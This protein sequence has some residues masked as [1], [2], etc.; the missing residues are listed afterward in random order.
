MR[1]GLPL[2][3]GLFACGLHHRHADGAGVFAR[4]GGR[5]TGVPDRWRRSSGAF[6]KRGQRQQARADAVG[7]AQREQRAEGHE[8]PGGERTLPCECACHVIDDEGRTEKDARLPR[9]RHGVAGVNK[10][11]T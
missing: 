9:L 5:G 7:D 4:R 10:L 6:G 8:D 2:A 3:C 1:R 11:L